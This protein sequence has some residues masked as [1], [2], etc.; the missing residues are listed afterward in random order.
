MEEATIHIHQLEVL[1]HVGVT[2]NERSHRQR[3]SLN[4]TVWP[5]TEFGQL[6]D[7]ITNAVNYSAIAVEVEGIV[8]QH[9]TKLIETLADTIAAQLVRSYPI[10]KATVEVQKFVLPGAEYVSVTAV[11][12]KAH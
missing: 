2:E 12:R 1:A 8:R 6:D 10:T 4:I 3:L 9:T 5:E 7:D 11:T